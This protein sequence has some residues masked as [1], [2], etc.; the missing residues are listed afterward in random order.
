[1]VSPSIK[2]ENSI[3]EKKKIADFLNKNLKV[4]ILQFPSFWTFKI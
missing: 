2:H 4:F 3:S 1:M